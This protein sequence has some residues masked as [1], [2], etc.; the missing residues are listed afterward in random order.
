EICQNAFR[1][2]E[3]YTKNDLE[4][5]HVDFMNELIDSF[6]KVDLIKKDN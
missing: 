2:R 1:A 4:D 3:K 6:N 5:Y